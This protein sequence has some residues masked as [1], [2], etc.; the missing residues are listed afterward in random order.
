MTYVTPR[1]LVRPIYYNTITQTRCL[2]QET[3]ISHSSGDGVDN[4]LILLK[5]QV[6]PKHIFPYTCPANMP[7]VQTMASLNLTYFCDTFE[8]PIQDDT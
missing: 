1:V 6:P 5:S 8:S 2:K 7:S 3:L 4:G